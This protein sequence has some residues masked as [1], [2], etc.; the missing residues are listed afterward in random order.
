MKKPV[1][2]VVICLLIVVEPR[3]AS[4]VAVADANNGTIKQAKIYQTVPDQKC[5]FARIGKENKKN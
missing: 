4:Y 2:N 5:T 3:G 1:M